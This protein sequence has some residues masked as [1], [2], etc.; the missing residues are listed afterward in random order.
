MNYESFNCSD[1][2]FPFEEENSKD[3]F[4]LKQKNQK[5]AVINQDLY[6][7]PNNRIRENKK[8]LPD[9]TFKKPN[10]GVIAVHFIM[11]ALIILIGVFLILFGLDINRHRTKI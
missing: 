10:P 11:H 7:I 8:K 4:K 3:I 6:V 1:C 9:A 2:S 5:L